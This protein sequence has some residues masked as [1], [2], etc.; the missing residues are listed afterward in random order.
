[1]LYSIPAPYLDEFTNSGQPCLQ[2]RTEQAQLRVKRARL[3]TEALDCL[4]EVGSSYLPLRVQASAGVIPA[5][6]SAARHQACTS[7]SC[8]VDPTASIARLGSA[9]FQLL[10]SRRECI[11]FVTRKKRNRPIESNP[12]ETAVALL[13]RDYLTQLRGA[14]EAHLGVLASREFGTD[15]RASLAARLPGIAAAADA[16]VDAEVICH[17]SHFVR[18]H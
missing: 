8:T 6:S 10:A 13:A 5:I 7:S 11:S 9:S 14:A 17:L 12:Q 18:A 4:R 16:V 3:V 1:M 15:P 2:E